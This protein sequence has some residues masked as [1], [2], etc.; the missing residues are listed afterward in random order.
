MSAG[1]RAKALEDNDSIL[2][3]NEGK[4]NCLRG[5]E[6]AV[7]LSCRGT[8]LGSKLHIDLIHFSVIQLLQDRNRVKAGQQGLGDLLSRWVP[9]IAEHQ[10]CFCILLVLLLLTLCSANKLRAE[11]QLPSM[12]ADDSWL[13]YFE[14]AFAKAA[15]VCISD[16]RRFSLMILFKPLTQPSEI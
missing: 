9:C 8:R 15:K 14:S 2:R 5:K 4:S 7:R 1:E 11:V 12:Q 13:K 10:T 6:R 16:F 3:A